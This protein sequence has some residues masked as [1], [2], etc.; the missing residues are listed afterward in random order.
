MIDHLMRDFSDTMEVR[1]DG[2]REPGTLISA[3]REALSLLNECTIA[4]MDQAAQGKSAPPSGAIRTG[5][6]GAPFVQSRI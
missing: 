6:P 1:L 5:L 3:E 4:K 2:M